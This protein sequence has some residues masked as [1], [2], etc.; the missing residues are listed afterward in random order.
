MTQFS[1]LIL[2]TVHGDTERLEARY[3]EIAELT[4]QKLKE[5]FEEMTDMTITEYMPF[6][7]SDLYSN[8]FTQYGIWLVDDYS[9]VG[10]EFG[11]RTAKDLRQK[12][13]RDHHD[14]LVKDL[15]QDNLKRIKELETALEQE[16]AYRNY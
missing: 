7:A 12:I 16:K 6:I 8:L 5:A 1:D 4:N 9:R 11:E 13:L 2:D 10:A 14:E 15:N 3:K